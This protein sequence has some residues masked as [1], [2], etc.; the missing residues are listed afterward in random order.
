MEE[1]EERDVQR[2]RERMRN[3]SLR[4]W[5]VSGGEGRWIAMTVGQVSPL[6]GVPTCPKGVTEREERRGEE[7]RGE[8]EA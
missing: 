7:R 4:H 8:E 5:D 6:S 3:D 1:K 2:E